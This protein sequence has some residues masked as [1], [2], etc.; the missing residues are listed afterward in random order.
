MTPQK[1]Q[2]NLPTKPEEVKKV[3]VKKTEPAQPDKETAPKK[4]PV[5]NPEKT[6]REQ[7]VIKKILKI[8][9]PAPKTEEQVKEEEIEEELKE[10]YEVEGEMPD[11][12]H[13]ERRKKRWWLVAVFV[14]LFLACIAAA[15]F[16]SWVFWKPWEK[17]QTQGLALE[18]LGPTQVTN[19]ESVIYKITYKNLEKIPMA[20][21]EIQANLPQEMQILEFTPEPTQENYTWEIGS[22]GS[23]ESGELKM[24]LYFQGEITT[25]L[26]IQALATYKPANF[27]SEFQEIKTLSVFIKDSLIDLAADGPSKAIPGEEVEYEIK[28]NNTSEFEYGETEVQVAY[29]DSFLFLESEPEPLVEAGNRWIF[30]NLATGTEEVIKI[31]GNFSSQ[32]Q[33]LQ[34]M[35]FKIGFK[36]DNQFKLQQEQVVQT[37]VLAGDLVLHLFI[38]G[39][40]S[41]QNVNFGEN[42]RFS[43]NYDNNSG[44]KIQD[45]ELKVHIE[46]DP[47]VGSERLV[48]WGELSMPVE[49]EG[50]VNADV[51]TWDKTVFEELGE[52]EKDSQGVIDF[53]MPLADEPLSSLDGKYEIKIWAEAKIGKIGDMETSREVSTTPAVMAINTDLGFEAVGRYFNEG[54]EALGFGPIPPAVGEMTGYHIFWT[55]TNTLH[56]IQNVRVTTTL[57]QDVMWTGRKNVEA[58][59]LDYNESTRQVSWTVNRLPTSINRVQVGFEVSIRPETDDVG[60][61]VKLTTENKL[62]ALDQKTQDTL[63]VSKD[64]I[65]SDI[66]LDEY[67]KG[68]GVVVES[69]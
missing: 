56:E 57:P 69:D 62:E 14:F 23:G 7:K 29:P 26:N 49:G 6:V 42:L 58:G 39:S 44:E 38:N 41:D 33:G 35:R 63:L 8:T 17:P 48:K 22:L 50:T 11:M 61:F 10:I 34:D 24:Q 64:W 36:R 30:S 65:L 4:E 59:D 45:V 2:K 55:V 3:E 32:G 15:V 5:K 46:S 25:S 54:G 40:E 68:K 27:S 21:L 51:I 37:E 18:I 1:K 28:F 67:A 53:S 13:L 12:T 20:N 60:T 43:L 19:G 16:A 9:K 31:K 47:A 52:V 66:P